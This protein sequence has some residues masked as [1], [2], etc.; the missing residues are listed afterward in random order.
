MMES[1]LNTGEQRKGK[2]TALRAGGTTFL[3]HLV[4]FI[5]SM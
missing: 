3:I 4:L 1:L 2:G 5:L